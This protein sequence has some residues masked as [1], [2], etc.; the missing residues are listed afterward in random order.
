M[1][2]PLNCWSITS[3]TRKLFLF[4]TAIII[5]RCWL[6]PQSSPKAPA[7]LIKVWGAC[8]GAKVEAHKAPSQLLLK[9][10]WE[11]NKLQWQQQQHPKSDVTKLG[12]SSGGRVFA[13]SPV[14]W[15]ETAAWSWNGRGLS[16]GSSSFQGW[17][18]RDTRERGSEGPAG[19]RLHHEWQPQLTG[20]I[21][22][23][24][25]TGSFIQVSFSFH[26]F[27]SASSAVPGLQW[28]THEI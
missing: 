5:G 19:T 28:H 27:H 21:N 7:S 2:S 4:P 14:N 25:L 6:V 10:R 1:N 15:A 23:S 18:S 17:W 24:M 12:M 20:C 22:C 13:M 3:V 26:G 16:L 9:G 11:T 8:Y